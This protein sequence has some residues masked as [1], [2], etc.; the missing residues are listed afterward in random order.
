[1]KLFYLFSFLLIGGQVF[2]QD[3]ISVL[4]IGNSY[5]YV[6]DLP[7]IV[8]S[9]S[10]NLGKT[11]SYDSQTAGGATLSTHA[12]NS[13][14]YVKI[15]SKPWDY[16]ILQAQSQ[17]PSFPDNQVD[18]QT[19]P[20]ALQIADSI[21]A[22]KFCTETMFFMTWGY[23]N[24]DPQWAPIST[25]DGMQTR[26][27]NAYVRFSDSVQGSVSPV[28]MAWK[29]V[30]ENYPTIDLYAPDGSH[31]SYAGSYLAACTFYAALYRESPVGCSFF[32]SLDPTTAA[33]L[34][35]AA[36]IS[37]LDSLSTWHLRPPSL[38]T[39][40]N[41]DYVQNG[42]QIDLINTS[43]KAQTY[44]WDLGD[45]NTSTAENLSHTYSGDGTYTVKLTAESEC[46]NDSNQVILDINLGG[47]TDEVTNYKWTIENV[48][49]SI[50]GLNLKDQVFITDLSG[51]I[52]AHHIVDLAPTSIDCSDLDRGVYILRII[53]TNSDYSEQIYL[54]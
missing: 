11:V 24:G 32:G 12:G 41:F 17:E 35:G 37:V 52:L 21:Y 20:F 49:L 28:G 10:S 31:P 25:Y 34:Q 16:V 54:R 1:M 29:Y 23:E 36:A 2:A 50:V 6:N 42:Y 8:D 3:S 15:N 46:N 43:W 7:G 39:T 5:T 22:N 44:F 53:G 51:K 26:L 40:A 27:R 38:H 47:I 48:L 4:F 18:T 19:L 45:G 13:A 33:Q 14:T 9:I 30:R